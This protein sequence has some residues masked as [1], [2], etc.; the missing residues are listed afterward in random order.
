M[1]RR[2]SPAEVAP[3]LG[4]YNHLV[5]VPADHELVFV[6]GQVGMLEDGTLAGPD[7]ESQTR[8]A[9][10]NI[11]T[12]LASFGAGPEH[13]VKLLTFLSGTEHLAGSRTARE[14]VFATWYPDG[15]W[16]A[17]SLMV[18]VA[19]AAPSLT[20]EVEAVAAVPVR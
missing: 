7:A 11:E 6:S 20:V 12:L 19:L 5:S 13:L 17:Q 3:P 4:Q 8:Q 1:I 18:V 15:A 10:A 2:W 16:P 14:E 9:L